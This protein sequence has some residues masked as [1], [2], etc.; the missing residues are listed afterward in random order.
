M[1]CSLERPTIAQGA[2]QL[3]KSALIGAITAVGIISL[4]ET[5]QLVAVAILCKCE[6]I[7]QRVCDIMVLHTQLLTPIF[8]L[9]KIVYPLGV[10]ILSATYRLTVLCGICAARS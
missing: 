4:I 7:P 6:E 8:F 3:L 10:A 5:I 1:R 2:Y 9:A